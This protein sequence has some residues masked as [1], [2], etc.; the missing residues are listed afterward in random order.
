[1]FD[2]VDV[3]AETSLGYRYN[4]SLHFLGGNSV[5]LINNGDDGI[6]MEGKI[7]T[8]VRRIE[9]N[10]NSRMRTDMTK[11]VYGLFRAASQ[12]TS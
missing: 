12:S 3:A 7:S 11:K 8:G 4:S 6:S 5:I 1:V 9:N 10:P 2:V